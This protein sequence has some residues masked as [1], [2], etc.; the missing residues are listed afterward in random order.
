[1]VVINIIHRYT[2]KDS[3]RASLEHNDVISSDLLLDNHIGDGLEYIMVEHVIDHDNVKHYTM[4]EFRNIFKKKKKPK[5]FLVSIFNTAVQNEE[6][7]GEFN[8]EKFFFVKKNRMLP[9]EIPLDKLV[10]GE[11]YQFTTEPK[12]V[13]CLV[14]LGRTTGLVFSDQFNFHPQMKK[15]MSFPYSKDSNPEKIFVLLKEVELQPLL[16]RWSLSVATP[17]D[18]EHQLSFQTNYGNHILPVK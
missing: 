15:F 6:C 18:G 16:Y 12:G 9:G 17:A 14:V 5:T 1:M 4:K 10:V 11:L 2:F 8:E 7:Y 3:F 13:T